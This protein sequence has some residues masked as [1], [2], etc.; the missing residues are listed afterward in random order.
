MTNSTACWTHRTFAMQNR[1]GPGDQNLTVLQLWSV[2]EDGHES[3]GFPP[4]FALA[5]E[6]PR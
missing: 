4:V 5:P 3:L 2:P 6:Q 1:V